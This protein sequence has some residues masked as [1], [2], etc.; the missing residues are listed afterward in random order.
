MESAQKNSTRMKLGEKTFSIVKF[1]ENVRESES[2]Q[3]KVKVGI[4]FLLVKIS[5]DVRESES[6]NKF[7]LVKI[8]EEVSGHPDPLASGSTTH[9]INNLKKH[10]FL[11]ERTPLLITYIYLDLE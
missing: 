8:C 6:G 3:E 2:E 9:P 10:T 7:L 5:E 4:Q 1:C 11:A